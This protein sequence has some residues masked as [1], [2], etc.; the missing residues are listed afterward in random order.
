MKTTIL[1]V[2]LC[3]CIIIGASTT[4]LANG[5]GRTGSATAGCN[6]GGWFCHGNSTGNTV[7]TVTPQFGTNVF[8]PGESRQI[9]AVVAHPTQPKAGI[10]VDVRN[11]ANNLVGT[12]AAGTGTKVVSGEITHNGKQDIVN[13]QCTFTFTWTA[14]NSTG[15]YSLKASGN[16]VNNNG[17]QSGDNW[18]TMTPMDIIVSNP[19]IQEPTAGT[20][21]CRGEVAIIRWSQPM[22]DGN[23]RLE[24]SAN[25]SNWT[26]IATTPGFPNF[27][28][29][30]VPADFPI[31]T[32]Y[33]MR[34]SHATKGTQYNS[35]TYQF[36]VVPSPVFVAQPVEVRTCRGRSVTFSV[37]TDYPSNYTFQWRHNFTPIAGAT[38]TSYTIP[39]V[40]DQNAGNYDVV[41][42]GCRPVTS[43]YAALILLDA[44]FFIKHPEN[45]DGCLGQ[46]A[47]LSVSVR[48][49]SPQLQWRFRGVPLAG[50][51]DSILTIPSLSPADTGLYDVVATGSCAPPGT[52]LPARLS[53]SKPSIIT[54]QTKDTLICL[55][56]EL[57]LGVQATGK[58]LTYR[59]KQ[60][61]AIVAENASP[62]Y[63][64]L[65]VGLPSAGTYTVDVINACGAVTSAKPMV[66]A[67]KMPVS[68]T[69]QPKDTTLR[70]NGTLIISV[71]ATGDTPVYEWYKSATKI[72]GATTNTLTI[73]NVK[74]SDAGKYSCVV[75]NSCG[76]MQSNFVNVNVTEAPAGPALSLNTTTLDF[77]C[78]SVGTT[79]I[80]K[81]ITKAITNMGGQ[82][83][84]V[85]SIATAQNDEKSFT[86][87]P[88]SITLQP[89][90]STD[91]T[92]TFSATER[93]E[94][95]TQ[96]VF[97]SNS[98]DQAGTIMLSAKGCIAQLSSSDMA[99]TLPLTIG[100]AKDTVIQF[101]NTGDFDIIINAM[102]VKGTAAND[103]SITTP[104]LPDTL[105]QAETIMIPL[106]FA[107]SAEGMRTAVMEILTNRGTFTSALSGEGKQISSIMDLAEAAGIEIMPNPS[108]NGTFTVVSHANPLLRVQI[109]DMLGS[110]VWESEEFSEPIMNVQ[111][112]L[113]H[114]A[115][116][117]YTVL[118]YTMTGI[119]PVPV[120]I[121]K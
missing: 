91:I 108:Y 13:G 109:T 87:S 38:S 84:I 45:T 1:H 52:S 72:Q 2:W 65:N 14:P 102:S 105:A 9:T 3:V 50:K 69:K 70:E 47:Q 82:P 98:I 33:R 117:Q 85:S 89:G 90:Q 44:P 42:T 46:P 56:R 58:N 118:I 76:S 20:K 54:S 27:Y 64:I 92:V 12:V 107:P 39:S 40:N 62:T 116:G 10:N 110:L 75:K 7:V 35:T 99:F 31:A 119:I 81:I 49:E 4:L 61:N 93:K 59:W 97:T 74:K 48:G 78:T 41:V 11:T 71:K 15:T 60:N 18:T 22:Y 101:A 80:Q 5:N 112:A 30:L 29:W 121:Q 24:V 79:P 28:Q 6:N 106:R 53:F 19:T 17:N 23:V 37:T 34:I 96:I 83:L 21:L 88:K 86:V 55:D 73:N 26:T 68:I 115:S 104:T 100:A 103:Y 94:Y 77:G 43:N 66:V 51:T 8:A 120:H 57:I 67:I 114:A 111:C 36:A 32:T 25:G 95:K 16:A 63:T 113:H